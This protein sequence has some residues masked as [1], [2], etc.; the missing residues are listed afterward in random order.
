M[1]DLKRVFHDL[2]RFETELWNALDARLRAEFDLPMGSFDIMQ[3]IARTGSCRV[4]D[5]AREQ[6]ITVGGTSKV[7][8]RIERLGFCERRSNPG[9]RR[10][11][12]IELTPAGQALLARA[13]VVFE[14][15][16]TSRLGAPLSARSLAQLATTLTA[17]RAS[18]ADGRPAP[19]PAANPSDLQERTV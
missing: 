19:D 17:L 6:A 3:V 5:I 18:A 16:L 8:D 13:T 14:A 4:H 12:I 7:V 15:E 10:S 9:D 11:S 1:T 2:V